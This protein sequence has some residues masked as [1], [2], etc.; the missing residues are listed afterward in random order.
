MIYFLSCFTVISYH[1][2]YVCLPSRC[3]SSISA[4]ALSLNGGQMGDLQ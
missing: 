2:R 1:L 4:E 3:A